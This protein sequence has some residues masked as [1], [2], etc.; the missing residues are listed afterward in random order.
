MW[1]SLKGIDQEPPWEADFQMLFFFMAA[2]D[3]LLFSNS[4]LRMSKKRN[5]FKT[6]FYFYI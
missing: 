3:N 2:I 1:Y 6:S 5:N 4:Y